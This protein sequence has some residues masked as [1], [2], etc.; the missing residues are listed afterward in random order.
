MI[1][2]E[3]KPTTI[4]GGVLK[5]TIAQSLGH[6]FILSDLKPSL[7]RER[8]LGNKSLFTGQIKLTFI[9]EEF[10]PLKSFSVWTIVFATLIGIHRGCHQSPL[11]PIANPWRVFAH[12]FKFVT[13]QSVL[14]RGYKSTDTAIRSA[15]TAKLKC[16]SECRAVP[17]DQFCTLSFN[18]FKNLVLTT[19]LLRPIPKQAD[20]FLP[21]YHH[22]IIFFILLANFR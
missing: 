18:N 22:S 10:Q 11:F 6:G 21:F 8:C 4:G 9:S 1:S 15:D 12:D 13:R 20:H 5:G 14:M 3:D 19:S 2:V 16:H 7:F 17:T